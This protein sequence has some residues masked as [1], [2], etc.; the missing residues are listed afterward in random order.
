MKKYWV[1]GQYIAQINRLL[2]FICNIHHELLISKPHQKYA[3][4]GTEKCADVL[5][6]TTPHKP[7]RESTRNVHNSGTVEPLLYDHPQNHIGVVV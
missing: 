6:D 5:V 1:N 2:V 7:G 3:Q 4:M